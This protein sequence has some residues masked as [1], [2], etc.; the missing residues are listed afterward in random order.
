MNALA[1][2]NSQLAVDE[3]ITWAADRNVNTAASA[4]NALAR[5]GSPLAYPVLL[6]A[7]KSYQYHWERTGA[8]SALLN[9]ARIVG[10]A[11]DI[12]TM[13]KIC[14]LL[15][16]KCNDKLTYQNKTTALGIY[17]SFHG[18]DAMKYL[19]KA[20]THPDKKYRNSAINMTSMIKEGAAIS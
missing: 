16:S 12:K 9:Y 15:I 18:L 11:G 17:V 4:Y 13:D 1:A 7:A 19:L 8:T 20:A 3:Y 2:M 10:E 5:S 14:K 6:N